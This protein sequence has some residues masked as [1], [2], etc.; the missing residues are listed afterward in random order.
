MK[1]VLDTEV[2]RSK[3]QI[4]GKD[5]PSPYNPKNSLVTVQYKI[6]ETGEK[7]IL[8]FNHK[9]L[10]H[11]SNYLEH[12]RL[13]QLLDDTTQLIGH[14]L[15]FDV[16]WLLECGFKIPENIKL[17]DTMIFEYVC[18]KGNKGPL[19]L[20]A[21]AE[22]YTL[23][24]KLDILQN[25]WLK[26]V[27]TDEIPLAELTEYALQDIETTYALYNL[28]RERYVNDKDVQYMWPAVQLTN[29]A[30]EVIIEMERNGCHI[31]LSALSAV[32]LEYINELT[33]LNRS[34]QSKIND[35]M[36]DTPINPA[37][38]DDMCMLLYGFEVK[39]KNAWIDKFGIGTSERNNVKKRKYPKRMSPAE[40]RRVIRENTES[41]YKTEAE[42]CSICLGNKKVRKTK[43]DGTPFKKDNICTNC[44]GIG[45]VYND[46]GRPAGLKLK[47]ISSQYATASGF[48]ADKKVIEQYLSRENLDEEVKAF[49]RALQRQSAITTYLSTF[50]EGIRNNVR[51]DMLLHTN[52]NQCI[53]ATGRLSSSNPN[54]QNLPRGSTFPVRKAIKSRF[55]KGSILE[56]DF[57][58]L[59]YRVA[60]MLAE[61]PVGLESILN[62]KD[63]H[64]IT[65]EIIYGATKDSVESSVWNQI[66][67]SAKAHTFKPL[68]GGE[69]GTEAE[70]TYYRA[71]LEEHT[72]IK[73]W[74]EELCNEALA[75]GQ[76]KTPTGRIF[77]FPNAKR[78]WDGKVK[79]KTQ[80]VNYPVQAVATADIIWI[81]IIDIFNEMK[82][83]KLSSKLMLQVHDAIVADIHPE[84]KEIMLTLFKKS[85]DKV[86]ELMYSR[87]KLKTEVPIDSE[88][89]IGE[90]WNDKKKVN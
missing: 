80:I 54:F 45:F 46:T 85:F 66:R 11:E 88:T 12:T 31:D 60:V 6:V 57:S 28:Q 59:E 1:L 18:N 15:K 77:A 32:E 74:H 86:H 82:K 79:G 35:L 70:Q 37:S 25:Y 84:E 7:D 2:T 8:V 89:S 21:L 67:Q 10:Q 43:V 52:L 36:G 13:Q 81:V 29:E 71:F 9:E 30:L 55:D 64:A 49:L 42:Q 47:P 83:L 17:Y 41:V 26:G 3:H 34:I 20:A 23:P 50:V 51:E 63:R 90:N 27:N 38:S 14:N 69:S 53:T 72:G 33:T 56:V 39:N 5:D 48:A 58:G 76:I 87:Y 4:S 19:S 40:L 22:K 68:Y 24:L 78:H 62:G 16:S 44:N 61:C 75:T 65:A 73:R